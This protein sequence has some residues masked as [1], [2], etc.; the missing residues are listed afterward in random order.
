[1][2]KNPYADL[3]AERFWRKVVAGVPPFALAPGPSARFTITRDARVATA[4]SCFAQHVARALSEAGFNHYLAEMAPSDLA[5]GI[6]ATRQYGTFSA[7]YGNV[8]TARQLL[9]LFDRAYGSFTPELSAW[10]R[11]DG[12]L[13]DPF[14]PGI[15]PEGFADE[16]ELAASRADHLAAVRTMFESLD[17]FVFTLGLTE[18]WMHRADGAMLPVAPGV[19]GGSF[20][21]ETYAF[22]NARAGEVRADMLV[23]LDRLFGVN[24]RARV[25]LTVSPVPLIAS[26]ADRHVLV[27]NAYS[28]AA[29]RVAAEEV[30][31]AE[32]RAIYFPS[33]EIVTSTANAARYY[34]DDLRTVTPA[35]V[36]HVMRVFLDAFT[37]T[38]ERS[39][40]T[41]PL[42]FEY[43]R[44]AGII[45]DEEAIERS[46]A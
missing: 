38:A 4:G 28:K 25:I 45:C 35:A 36:A 15:D 9:Q 46:L 21:P 17:V 16:S 20:D 11:P 18:G 41:S 24:P 34:D 23:F 14:R 8:Y 12:R 10:A 30:C 22:V 40:V 37:E 6:A 33:Y 1:M 3:P 43:A 44:A 31:A 13:V 29:L 27:S 7:R 32:P 42:G 2:V 5:A 26:Y 39:I 19:I